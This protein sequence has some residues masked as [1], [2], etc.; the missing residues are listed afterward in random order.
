MHFIFGNYKTSYHTKKHYQNV[1]D[2][3]SMKQVRYQVV[4]AIK[5]IQHFFIFDNVS[6]NS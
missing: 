3:S 1:R 2:L 5:R 4:M 6:C